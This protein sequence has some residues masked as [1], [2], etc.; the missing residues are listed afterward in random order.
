ML[1]DMVPLRRGNQVRPR[2]DVVADTPIRGDLELTM[3]R[4]RWNLDR[5]GDLPNITARLT[6]PGFSG[7]ALDLRDALVTKMRGESFLVYGTEVA[8]P[9][10]IGGTSSFA[11]VW[12][13]RVVHGAADMASKPRDPRALPLPR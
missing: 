12:W 8:R 13:C 9:V 1:V 11:Q 6:L 3:S 2:A 10:G 7:Q 4:G 5:T